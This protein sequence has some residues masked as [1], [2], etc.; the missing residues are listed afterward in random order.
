MQPQRGL[1]LIELLVAMAILAL[2]AAV[3]WLGIG[4]LLKTRARTAVH[5]QDSM[6]LHIALAQIALDL[7]QSILVQGTAPLHWDGKVL[8]LTRRSSNTPQAWPVVVGWAVVPGVDGEWLMRWVSEPATTR[9]QWQAAWEAA[10][11]WGRSGRAAGATAL[12]PA[13]GLQVQFWSGDAWTNAQS[14]VHS[15]GPV[16]PSGLRMQIRTRT[17][18]I[19]KNWAHPTVVRERTP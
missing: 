3:S 2:M 14:A 18:E 17:G 13:Q 1:T 6:A 12:V 7:D 4:S 9:P 10:A 15:Q 11:Q 16:A 8:R 19:V 5:A